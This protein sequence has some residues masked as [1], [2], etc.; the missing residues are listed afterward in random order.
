M[1]LLISISP[2]GGITGVGYHPR[3]LNIDLTMELN[4]P[5]KPI[6]VTLHLEAQSKSLD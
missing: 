5:G 1:I 4:I 2:E 3:L 6:Q